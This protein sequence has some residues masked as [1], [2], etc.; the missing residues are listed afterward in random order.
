M[1]TL[2]RK[3]CILIQLVLLIS[4]FIIAPAWAQIEEIIVTAERRS[5]GIQDVPLSISAFSSDAMEKKQIDVTK[6]I[7][8]H[9][10][11]L[12][13]YTLTA[14][15][16]AI[17]VHMRGVSVQNGGMMTSETPVG[18]YEDDI[19]RGRM[20][21]INTQL[22]DIERVEVLRG[23]QATLYGRNTISGA[24][25]IISRTPGDEA[26]K[27]LSIG[28][29]N[30]ETSLI[31][32]S[33]GGPIEEGSLS[34]SIALAYGDRGKGYFDNTTGGHPGEYDRHAFR[35]KLHWYEN[36]GVDIVASVFS[37]GGKNDGLNAV[38]YGPDFDP[39][40]LPT[41]EPL[42]GFYCACSAHQSTGDSDHSGGT[43][44]VTVD[45]DTGAIL[46]SITAI[47]D[48]DDH[49]SF[50]L[51]GG[52]Y[53]VAPGV[54][55]TGIQGFTL[56]SNGE[57]DQFSQEFQLSGKA[58]DDQ[59]DW[60]VGLYYMEEEGSQSFSGGMGGD[61]FFTEHTTFKTDSV[62]F[63]TQLTYQMS[64]NLSLTA[65]ARYTEDD[66]EYTNQCISFFMCVGPLTVVLDESFTETT[67][68]LSLEYQWKENVM[69]YAVVASGF[70]AGGFQTLCIANMNC[71]G[72][73]YDPQTVWNYEIGIKSDLL[74]NTLRVNASTFVAKYEDIQQ[75]IITGNAY[76]QG[77]VG[78]VDVDGIELEMTWVASEN[79]SLF[80]TLGL[81]DSDYGKVAANSPVYATGADT[82]PSTPDYSFNAGF[83][84]AWNVQHP[85]YNDLEVFLGANL[86]KTDDYFSEATNA[87]LIPG[88][89][90]VN[91]YV[92][93][94][95]LDGR[96]QVSLRGKNITDE[97][98][99]VSGIAGAG[100]NIRTTE[101]PAEYML[102]AKFNF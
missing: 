61:P 38:P 99:Y 20:A 81:M 70:Q 54:A 46:K 95:P 28:Y 102:T 59:L 64:D 16:D 82:L 66:K 30:Y 22:T 68:K 11:N 24:V 8:F 101:P 92:G 37:S 76:P 63:F 88:Y 6:D 14:G 56:T 79:L 67:P 34:G 52:G 84:Y 12:L 91:A 25:K 33:L 29:G 71:A 55:I 7:A 72:N 78:E 85:F 9:V 65:G 23:P 4:I 39:P 41:G 3:N 98:Y 53:Q 21:A 58:K 60:I 15:G 44:H 18:F 27:N 45:L 80:A 32:A 74:D 31:T 2:K 62:A 96:W 87:L 47:T 69:V 43:L 19:Y 83:D 48:L 49:F 50:D 17:Q 13:A 90:L 73:I 100:T 75:T 42:A 1:K 94:R 26:W 40:T 97:E 89:S 35:G 77:N 5:E 93:I 36:D 51:N 57:S 86:F 10:P